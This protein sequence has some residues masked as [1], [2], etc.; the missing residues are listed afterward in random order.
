MAKKSITAIAFPAEKGFGWVEKYG[1]KYLN[2]KGLPILMKRDGCQKEHFVFFLEVIE[3]ELPYP[4]YWL[5]GTDGY[6]ASSRTMNIGYD[7][8]TEEDALRLQADVIAWLEPYAERWKDYLKTDLNYR[9]ALDVARDLKDAPYAHTE[10]EVNAYERDIAQKF[11]VRFPNIST[12][13]WNRLT[14]AVLDKA[15]G[16]VVE[17]RK[18]REFKGFASGDMH[19]WGSSCK[20]M[21]TSAYGL[22]EL[23]ALR[24]SYLAE[25]KKMNKCIAE[26]EKASEA[27]AYWRELYKGYTEYALELKH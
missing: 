27:D 17:G 9:N 3:M 16:E 5:D 19:Y 13:S 10:D 11:K 23:V 8:L 15:T 7:V 20:P 2:Y 26:W 25:I 14:P 21:A 12:Y 1:R 18:V 24:N 6:Y 22:D 4:E